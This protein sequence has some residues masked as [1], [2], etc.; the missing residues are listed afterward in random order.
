MVSCRGRGTVI[1]VVKRKRFN[2]RILDELCNRFRMFSYAPVDIER[3]CHRLKKA[4]YLSGYSS[5]IYEVAKYIN[6][7]GVT[8]SDYHLKM[9][10]AT[11]E[12]TCIFAWRT[13]MSRMKK[14]KS[15]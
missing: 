9:I 10:K 14:E 4:S 8:M 7:H 6:E 2:T 12:R 13:C 3:F 5:M 1:C 15:S 11:S